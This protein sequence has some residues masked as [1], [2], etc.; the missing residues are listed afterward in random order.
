MKQDFQEQLRMQVEFLRSSCAAFDS[1]NHRE[2]IR[3]ATCMRV[4]FHD[5]K[6]SISLLTHLG[7]KDIHLMPSHLETPEG[8]SDDCT[9]V[10]FS[11]GVISLGNGAGSYG[12]MLEDFVPGSTYVLPFEKWWNEIISSVSPSEHLTRK[13][14]VLGAANKDGGAHVDSVLTK[15]YADYSRKPQGKITV[16]RT[17]LDITDMHLVA[18][19]TMGNEVLKSPEFLVLL[20]D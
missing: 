14:L 7:A 16:G 15:E 9:V 18:L 19:R 11:M 20:K 5:T 4:L 13:T 6:R 8:C 12:P 10:V 1:G 2:A 3:I 17:E